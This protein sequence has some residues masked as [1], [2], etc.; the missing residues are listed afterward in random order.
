MDDLRTQFVSSWS[1]NAQYFE[2]LKLMASLSKL[3]S[4]NSIPYLDY[5]LTENLFCKYFNAINDARSC[6]AYDA[7]IGSLG[8]GIKTFGIAS[9][10]STEKIAEF[11]K[12]KPQLD[13][14]HG[15][16]LA[17]KL[18]QFRNDRIDFADNTYGVSERLYHIVGRIDG[19]LQIFNSPYRRIDISRIS[20]VSESSSSLSFQVDD[21]LYNFNK[22]KSVLMKRFIL[23]DEHTDV[24]VDILDDPLEA[25][26]SLL[27]PLNPTSPV[28]PQ[29]TQ[30]QHYHQI[31]LFQPRVKGVDY[32][33]LPLYSTRGR[34]AIV[35]Q[36][37]GLNQWNAAGR[38]RDENEVYIPVPKS[39]NKQ[40]PHFFPG[41]EVS[42]VLILPTGE[43][44]SAKICQAGD[45]ALMSNPNSALGK[46]I[47]RTVLQKKPG[48]LVTMDDLVRFGIDSVLIEKTHTQDN[49]G[50]EKY[51]ISF[52][53]SDYESY[54]DFIG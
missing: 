38:R 40:Y 42:F 48:E 51:K 16:E 11:N 7:R 53:T 33:V 31:T 19:A 35:P 4:E 54:E 29:Q 5:R 6:T 43:E 49:T 50:Q 30:F 46:W 27:N 44:L 2:M 14:F 52:T 20:N 10:A 12:L 25:L 15:V 36:K 13:P 23:P 24:T 45:K 26:S 18:A 34:I 3:F 39:L 37:S 28:S 47:L 22:S 21:D 9:G 1:S 17:E 8:I 32:V 41:H